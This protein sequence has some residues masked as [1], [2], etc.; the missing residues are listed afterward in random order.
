LNNNQSS[1][2][3]KR[4]SIKF[5]QSAVISALQR[6]CASSNGFSIMPELPKMLFDEPYRKPFTC[7]SIHPIAESG[8]FQALAGKRRL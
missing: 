7:N 4:K 2:E 8:T 3:I 5:Q 1:G 6:I